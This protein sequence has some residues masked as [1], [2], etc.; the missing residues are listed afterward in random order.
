[1]SPTVGV[2]AKRKAHLSD[3]WPQATMSLGREC[4]S[5]W[6]SSEPISPLVPK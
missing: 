1:M 4:S 5:S 2:N 6:Y 3:N